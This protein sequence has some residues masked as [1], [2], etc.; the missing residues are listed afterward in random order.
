MNHATTLDTVATPAS[1]SGNL[2]ARALHQIADT[3]REVKRMRRE[4]QERF[5]H[6]QF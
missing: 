6:L 4:A 1:A 2:V 3:I 5:P